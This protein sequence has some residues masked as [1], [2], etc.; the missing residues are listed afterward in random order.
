M[1][2]ADSRYPMEELGKLRETD[3][4]EMGPG[5][6]HWKSVFKALS[7]LDG[8]V[9]AGVEPSIHIKNLKKYLRQESSYD[10]SKIQM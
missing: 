3:P 8:E 4:N 2:A 6:N 7:E 9:V 5:S 1:A 10:V